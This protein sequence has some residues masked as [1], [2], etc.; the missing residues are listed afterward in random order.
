MKTESAMKKFVTYGPFL[1]TIAVAALGGAVT[2]AAAWT[3]INKDIDAA[4]TQIT[5]LE[6]QRGKDAEVL[7]G[8]RESQARTEEQIKAIRDLLERGR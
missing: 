7:Q 6:V 1:W 3:S 4:K 5:S 2:A 8:M